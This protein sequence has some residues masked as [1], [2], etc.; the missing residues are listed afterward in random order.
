MF[1]KLLWES[2]FTIY[3]LNFSQFY[4]E[5]IFHHFQRNIQV[6]APH[7]LP[8]PLGCSCIICI[9]CI[10]ICKYT[11]I[12]PHIIST[13]INVCIYTHQTP[14]YT[15]Y[16]PPVLQFLLS[17]YIRTFENLRGRK[18]FIIFTQ[19]LT[20]SV[21]FILKIFLGIITLLLEEFP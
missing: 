15:H 16:S 18:Q 8:Y 19:M 7:P 14:Q 1:W 11:Y 3:I 20:I 6:L 12:K 4:L 9:L 10:F 13:H 2:Q 21:F 17:I 5:V